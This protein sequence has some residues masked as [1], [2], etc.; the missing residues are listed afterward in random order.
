MDENINPLS[1]RMYR[2][3]II[4]L[5]EPEIKGAEF[6]LMNSP[7]YFKTQMT[8]LAEIFKQGL[9]PVKQS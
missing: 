2:D 4:L 7:C 6:N 5:I 8:D 1:G 9:R 3:R